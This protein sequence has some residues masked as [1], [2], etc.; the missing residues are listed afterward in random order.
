MQSVSQNIIV[1]I[2]K[3]IS[4][5]NLSNQTSHRIR[6]STQMLFV[7]FLVTDNSCPVKLVNEASVL[8][9]RIINN[10]VVI[11]VISLKVVHGL[12][13][14]C[15][16]HEYNAFLKLNIKVQTVFKPQDFFHKSF[17]RSIFIAIILKLLLIIYHWFQCPNFLVF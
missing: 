5:I 11:H 16:Y 12:S 9:K 1:I 14:N 7:C 4:N 10:T 17:S 3:L 6:K 13:N 8:T 2:F 15:H